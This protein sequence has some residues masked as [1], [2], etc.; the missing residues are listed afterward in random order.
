VRSSS[1]VNDSSDNY[2]SI[3]AATSTT[4]T[5]SLRLDASSPVTSIAPMGQTGVT[6]G[7]WKLYANSIENLTVSQI[8]VFNKGNIKSSTMVRNLTLYCGSDQ[9]GTSQSAL[10]PY[11]GSYYG[12]FGG[13][14][15]V[16]PKGSNK[17][18]T[19]KGDITSYADSPFSSGAY[20]TA[21]DYMQFYMALP[22]TITGIST[23]SM[24]AR[25]ANGY[26]KVAA[27]ASV[28]ASPVYPYRTNLSATMACQGSCT[29]RVRAS[30]DR[31][32]VLTLTGTAFADAKL[33]QI[34]LDVGGNVTSSANGTPWYLTTSAGSRVATGIYNYASGMVTLVPIREI[35]VGAT[36]ISYDIITNTTAML[37]APQPG[38]SPILT[39]SAELGTPSLAGDLRWDDQA[40]N[41]A[42]PITWL[43]GI[44]PISV[45]ESFGVVLA[46]T[47]PSITVLSPN[48]GEQWKI[49]NTYDIIWNST[50]LIGK[51]V[52]INLDVEIS[53]P[54]NEFGVIAKYLTIKRGVLADLGRYSWNVPLA[55]ENFNLAG[56]EKRYKIDIGA[57]IIPTVIGV[58]DI[59]DNYFS[60]VAVATTTPSITVLSPNGG[61]KLEVGKTYG[62]KWVPKGTINPN[63]NVNIELLSGAGRGWEITY[64][65]IPVGNESY[66]WTVP[67]LPADN[68]VVHIWLNENVSIQDKSDNYFS[69]IATTTSSTYYPI[70]PYDADVKTCSD[71][72]GKVYPTTGEGSAPWFN[73]GGCASNKYYYVNPGQQLKLNAYTDSCSVCAC[74]HPNFYLYEYENGTWVNKKYFDLPDVQSLNQ[75]QYYTPSSKMIKIYAPSCFY[76]TV[77]SPQPVQ[78]SSLNITLDSSTPFSATIN[79]G[80]TNVTFSVIKLSANSSADISNI[81]WL[82]I[83]SDS[84][85]ASNYL[86][87]IKVFS[88]TIQLGAT[89]SELKF[90]GSYYAESINVSG[91]SIPRGTYKLLTLVADIKP[92]ATPNGSVRLGFDGIGFSGSGPSVA[93]IPVYG[94]NMTI[95]NTPSITVLSPNGGETWQVGKTYAITWNASGFA[96]GSTLMIALNIFDN[97]KNY[98]GKSVRPLPYGSSYAMDFPAT[99]DSYAWTVPDAIFNDYPAAKYFKISVQDN[100]KTGIVDSSDNYFSIVAATTTTPLTCDQLKEAPAS[101]SYFGLCKNQ[102]YDKVCFNKYNYVYQGCGKSSYND[103]TV[104]NVNA[105]QNIWCDSGLAT[106]TL[107]ITIL[108]PNGGEIWKIGETRRINWNSTGINS[109][110]IS[111]TDHGHIGIGS[112]GSMSVV[113][114][115]P[116]LTG[117]YD[118]KIPSESGLPRNDDGSRTSIDKYKINI[119]EVYTST[120]S[121]GVMNLIYGI[122]DSSDNFFSIIASPTTTISSSDAS[123]FSATELV[124][125]NLPNSITFWTTAYCPGAGTPFDYKI[126]AGYQKESCISGPMGSHGGCSYCAMSKIKLNIIATSTPSGME[127]IE[128]QLAN[129]S[130]AVARL[131]EEMKGFLNR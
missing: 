34:V 103:C 10:I 17:L 93:G 105:A 84:P 91:F 75:D 110:Y 50:G 23:D 128:N 53:D 52:D 130:S 14:T 101:L 95:S 100:G 90:N 59:S 131:I 81:N 2:F 71:S 106:T 86:T 32:G 76:L 89:V 79:P 40:I 65:K 99:N 64:N 129:I 18:I 8:I 11:S 45:S 122:G 82:E 97:N 109:V 116:A 111:L 61:E 13:A 83:G 28:S 102:G 19:L 35:S 94:N 117:Y 120:S 121:S 68:Y 108:S 55:L 113:G 9:F 63:S 98:I 30:Y 12:G 85:S 25:G 125:N 67:S 38:F 31:V 7:V 77:Y 60:I 6:L 22:A 44:S 123:K 49:G 1:S 115:I 112:G 48:G 20:I 37:Q 73:W 27:V 114:P 87:N 26:A 57:D 78:S 74:N 43:G 5:I 126:P 92:T 118:W 58:K 107:S 62:I 24:V 39:F 4:G 56:N 119:F 66:N 54:N 21:E 41:P 29:N 51:N 16:I 69:I 72:S 96:P 3:V 36:P 124:E 15:C 42:I 33:Q 104:N 46:T 88:G 47:T 80:Q 127:S 70:Y